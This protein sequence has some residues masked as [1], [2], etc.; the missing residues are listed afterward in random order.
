MTVSGR[1]AGNVAAVICLSSAM[2]G[3]FGLVL[4]KTQVLWDVAMLCAGNINCPRFE[5][6]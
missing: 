3:A 1:S 4:L 2:S 5:G 6:C